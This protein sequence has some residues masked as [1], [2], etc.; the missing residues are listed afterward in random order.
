MKR[1]SV[2]FEVKSHYYMMYHGYYMVQK[3]FNEKYPDKLPDV[4]DK[5]GQELLNRRNSSLASVCV[6]EEVLRNSGHSNEIDKL[7]SLAR[8]AGEYQLKYDSTER[9]KENFTKI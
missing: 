8:D 6:L 9:Y 1:K 5:E 4:T 3:R 7:V 2:L